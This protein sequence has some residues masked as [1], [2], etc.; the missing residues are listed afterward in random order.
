[1]ETAVIGCLPIWRTWMQRALLFLLFF[2]SLIM[3]F[4]PGCFD[5]GKYEEDAGSDG[6]SDTGAGDVVDMPPDGAELPADTFVEDPPYDVLDSTD[7][8]A[9]TVVDSGDPATE[10]PVCT[11]TELAVH[12]DTVRLMLLL[13]Q[14]SS[15]AGSSWTFTTAAVRAVVSDPA[16]SDVYFGLDAHPD[17]YP[18]SWTACGSLCFGC[19]DDRCGTLFPPQV[20]LARASTSSAG[21]VAHMADPDYPQFCTLSP[22]VSQMGYYATG[23]GSSVVPELYTGDGASYLVVFSD[24]PN[25]TDCGGDPAVTTLTTYP[26]TKTYVIGI[27]PE[28]TGD[29]PAQLNAIASNGG[30]GMSSY[31]TTRTELEVTNALTTILESVI[32][33]VYVVD[34]P[35]SITDPS[36]VNF[37]FDDVLVPYDSGCTETSGDGWTWVAGGHSRVQFCGSRCTAIRHGSVDSVTS[38]QGCPSG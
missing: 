18:G 4:A 7:T 15:M 11:E 35:S 9:D 33:C 29:H 6:T 26:S 38:T 19:M 12:L 21:I 25:S 17:G 22:L 3:G 23:P 31:F 37:Y 28:T 1:M 16:Y 8:T 32:E 30:T 24:G 36:L 20:A 34:V 10:D 27:M 2:S 14:S 5:T 13:D